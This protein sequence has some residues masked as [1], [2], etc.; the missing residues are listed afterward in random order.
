MSYVHTPQCYCRH[1]DHYPRELY[2]QDEKS[3]R[4][5]FRLVVEGFRA[6]KLIVDRIRFPNAIVC[7]SY[8]SQSLIVKIEEVC[9]KLQ[10][11]KFNQNRYFL[12]CTYI[13]YIMF[14]Q[15]DQVDRIKK[16]IIFSS[17]LFP[18]LFFFYHFFF[19]LIISH[20][21]KGPCVFQNVIYYF[22]QTSRA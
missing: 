13:L 5:S 4:C 10:C 19:F 12:T 14:R 3:R 9:R 16:F 2:K 11:V 6:A 7:A 17:F 21:S 22:W 15:W 8:C 18:F 20:F 1:H